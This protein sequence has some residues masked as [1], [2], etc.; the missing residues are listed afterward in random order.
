VLTAVRIIVFRI[1]SGAY[2][3][4]LKRSVRVLIPTML[5]N[6]PEAMQRIYKRLSSFSPTDVSI[7]FGTSSEPTSATPIASNVCPHAKTWNAFA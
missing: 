4:S 1:V 6:K 3:V 7:G 5:K 2:S